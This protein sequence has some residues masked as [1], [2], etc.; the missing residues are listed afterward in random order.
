MTTRLQKINETLRHEL[1]LILLDLSEKEWGIVTLTDVQI[2]PDLSTARV[3]IDGEEDIIN[4]IKK[5]TPEIRKLLRPRIKFKYIPRL[6][7]LKED[8]TIAHIEEML[9]KIDEK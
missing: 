7:F 3:W 1:S 8:D 5:H 9:E 2:S 6:S 4:Q